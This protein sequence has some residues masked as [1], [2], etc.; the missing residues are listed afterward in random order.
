MLSPFNPSLA[1]KALGLTRTNFWI[2]HTF[3]CEVWWLHFYT[4]STHFTRCSAHRACATT[5]FYDNKENDRLFLLHSIYYYLYAFTLTPRILG[6]NLV[7]FAY[8][9]EGVSSTYVMVVWS[10]TTNRGS[11][12]LTE[13]SILRRVFQSSVH[14]QLLTLPNSA[15]ALSLLDP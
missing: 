5:L 12:D 3:H 13:Q 9:C 6:V 7:K 15:I 8:D 4:A 14:F 2:S 11:L 1:I 10:Q